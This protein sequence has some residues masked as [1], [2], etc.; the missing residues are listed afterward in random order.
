MADLA[1]DSAV[2]P[3]A[4]PDTFTA[5][6]IQ[7]WNIW[8][9]NGG[10]LASI[11]LRAAGAATALGR[12]A[13]ISC[14]F[15]NVG[16]FDEVELTVT[17][18]RSSR[19]AEALQV[20]MAQQDRAILHAVVWAVD[21]TL[22]GPVH[23]VATPPKVPGP[24]EVRTVQE[25]GAEAGEAP[26]PNEAYCETRPVSWAP[27][28]PGPFGEA[29]LR[30]WVRLKPAAVFPSDPWLDAC[31]SVLHIDTTPFPALLLSLAKDKRTFFAPTLDLQVAFHDAAPES[32]WL[33]AEGHGSALGNGLAA[34]RA[35][36]WSPDGRLLASGSQQMLCRTF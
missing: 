25:M 36:V 3:G 12:P 15:L 11:A 19:K 5:T 7:D 28:E 14:Q 35:A 24:E 9:P 21:A 1:A 27:D 29:T 20:R 26:L 18:L 31:R 4:E 22:P 23:P 6:L 32:E 8:G 30:G 33:L 13:S 34:G 16:K 10:Y 2:R 17:R